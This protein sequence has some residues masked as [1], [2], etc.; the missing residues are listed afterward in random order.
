VYTYRIEDGSQEATRERRSW[1]RGSIASSGRT[2]S[3]RIGLREANRERE[4]ME[5]T[6][7][8]SSG[9]IFIQNRGWLSG[10][11]KI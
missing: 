6:S 11:P 5:V 3:K 2:R 9:K 10:R 1:R 8:A 7:T 4:I